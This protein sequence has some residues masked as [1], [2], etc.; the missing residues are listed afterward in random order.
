MDSTKSK[1]KEIELKKN[2][3][4]QMLFQ[5]PAK[6]IVLT[7]LV[8][9]VVF[10]V[11]VGG[12]Y[13]FFKGVNVFPVKV[14]TEELV[15]ESDLPIPTPKPV[16]EDGY[17][18]LNVLLLGYGGAGHDG[19]FLTDVVMLAH[20]DTQAKKLALISVPRDLW[21][22]VG[23]GNQARHTK[24]NAAF[25]LGTSE[26]QYP[27]EGVKHTEAVTGAELVKKAVSEV[28]GFE[29]DYF[30]G[31]DFAGFAQAIDIL[32]GV[33]VDVP[34]TFDD[35]FYPVKGRELEPCGKTPEEITELSTTLSGFELEKQF[36][37][38][39]EHLSF[40]EGS[41]RMNGETA[42]KFV[43][44]RHSDTHGGDFSRS[45]R[46]KAVLAG[47]RDTL[48]SVRALDNAVPFFRKFTKSIRTDIDEGILQSLVPIIGDVSEY[49]IVSVSLS[50]DNVL[51]NSKS[52]AG[53]YILVPKA[54]DGNW[55]GVQEFVRQEIGK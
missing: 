17:K 16:P 47:V 34:H 6:K 54:G 24:I 5:H 8:L 14:I 7:T 25:T 18:T 35:Y 38:R 51:A 36:E 27:R 15:S 4:F 20:F 28:T 23:S 11:S 13:S 21:V 31:V 53:A 26:V 48:L 33:E 43:R 32:G 41:T 44:S 37:C 12:A 52:S 42:L 2:T 22:K 1:P 3:T 40:V 46:Q 30:I 29:T 10:G 19:G 39:Y 55:G 50:T 49:E 45:L 9:L